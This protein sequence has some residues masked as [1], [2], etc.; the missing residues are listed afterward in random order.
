MPVKPS[1]RERYGADW[2]QFAHR[3]KFDRADGRC[4]C[5][6]RCGDANCRG[7]IDGR[8]NAKHGEPHPYNGKRV[9]LTCAHLTHDETSREE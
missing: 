3:I 2:K 5:D 4:E 9:I 8:C 7:L 6:G 1:K